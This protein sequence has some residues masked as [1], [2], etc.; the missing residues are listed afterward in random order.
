MLYFRFILTS[1][2]I[3]FAAMIIPIEN[4]HY[5]RTRT[6]SRNKIRPISAMNSFSVQKLRDKSNS[7]ANMQSASSSDEF[8]YIPSPSPPPVNELPWLPRMNYDLST[9]IYMLLSDPTSS[10]LAFIISI[11]ITTL[12]VL[13][14]ITFIL[15]S[16]PQYRVLYIKIQ[17]IEL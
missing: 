14:C 9:F 2:A 1:P 16:L 12:I 13:S 15:E 17:L 7:S 6:I 4:E 10:Y 8:E 3:I 11:I 5:I